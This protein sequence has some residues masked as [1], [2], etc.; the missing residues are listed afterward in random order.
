MGTGG[1]FRKERRPRL[2]QGPRCQAYGKTGRYDVFYTRRDDSFIAL[3][4]RVAFARTHHADL[5]VSIHANSFPGNSVR[6]AIV[7]TVSDEASDKMAADVAT[8]ENQSDALAGIDI[9]GEDSDQVKDILLDL[10]RRETRNFGVVFA[11]NLIK[12]LGTATTHFK[13]PHSQ[14]G[15]SSSWR[16]RTCPSAILEPTASRVT[17]SDEKQLLPTILVRELAA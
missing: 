8:A 1:N 4:E 17:N 16:C 5:F 6:G 10:T 9:D 12:S 3:G 11:Q 13:A 7:Y 14:A 2:R 15:S